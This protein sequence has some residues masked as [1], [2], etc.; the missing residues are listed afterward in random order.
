[1]ARAAR[2]AIGGY[3]YVRQGPSDDQ[4][5]EP[6][7]VEDRR[8]SIHL[9]SIGLSI[10]LVAAG[11]VLLL[12]SEQGKDLLVLTG[13]DGAKGLQLVAGVDLLF[14]IIA[15]QLVSALELTKR[16][17]LLYLAVA[18]A[19]FPSALLLLQNE[20]V[21]MILI[22][23]LACSLFNMACVPWAA[24]IFDGYALPLVCVIA[25]VFLALAGFWPSMIGAWFG[26]A[27]VLCLTLSAYMTL[28]HGQARLSIKLAGTGEAGGMLTWWV[29][30]SLP[31]FLLAAVSFMVATTSTYWGMPYFDRVRT[32]AKTAPSPLPDLAQTYRSWLER[33]A[34]SPPAAGSATQPR[35]LVLVAAAGGGIRASYWTARLL[36]EIAGK[37][38]E[39]ETRLFA[40][41]GVS[42]GSLGLGVFYAALAEGPERCGKGGL[43]CIAQFHETDFLAAPLA[44]TIVG[45]PGNMLIPLAPMP[46]RS[47]ALETIWERAWRTAL[48]PN[49]EPGDRLAEPLGKLSSPSAGPILVLNATSASSGDR[50]VSAS[51]GTR[52]WF[53]PVG[54]C[55]VN[56][57]EHLSLPLSAGIGASARFPV[58]TEWGW[59]DAKGV[60][61]CDDYEGV[62]DGGFYDNYGAATLLDLLN[63]IARIRAA[64]AAS[65]GTV[66]AIKP[67]VIQITSDPDAAS[68]CVLSLLDRDGPPDFAE[69]GRKAREEAVPAPNGWWFYRPFFNS[70]EEAKA[71]TSG[72]WRNTAYAPGTLGYPGLLSVFMRSRMASGIRVAKLL[73]A[74]MLDPRTGGC[75]Y[76]FSM[77]GLE[78]VPLGWALSSSAR[79]TIDA[80]L[81][82][83]HNRATM[84]ALIAEL[85]H[86]SPQCGYPE[87]AASGLA[88]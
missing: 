87:A 11:A 82:S 34:G 58:I 29:I 74:T 17:T 41:S 66:P 36:A 24:R 22:T 30:T 46:S 86:P 43:R 51:I 25:V 31:L 40:A 39:I 49:S 44:A 6:P 50:L 47:F 3:R 85:G 5:F 53:D 60:P 35:Q 8:G 62:A 67:I 54:A 13:D 52:G 20:S 14:A 10:L 32:I 78:G 84:A 33:N 83:D 26:S 70:N 2:H 37:A 7:A 56:L 19:V 65:Q 16:R 72:L 81:A 15:M 4:P 12:M 64:D 80:S 63:G 42:G 45:I 27:L 55:Q 18:A 79:K 61:G 21:G 9:I 73:R 75:Y 28:L 59:F 77:T 38:P 68:A 69:C 23:L 57:A 76:H 71:F 48:A 88:P 1:M